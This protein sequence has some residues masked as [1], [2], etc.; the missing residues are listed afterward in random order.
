M[1]LERALHQIAEIHGHLA[2]SEVYRGYRSLPLALSG[3]IALAAAGL[4]ETVLVPE[5]DVAFV[6]YWVVIAAICGALSSSEVIYHYLFRDDAFRRRKTRRV[7]GQFL[8]SLIGGGALTVCLVKSGPS[9][10]SLIPGLWAILFGM[11]IFASRPYLPRAIG[12]VGLFYLIA[13]NLLL[14]LSGGGGLNPWGM[15][16]TFGTGQLLT[17]L[18]LYWN[19]ERREHA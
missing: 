18:V 16:V 7:T 17:A 5:T 2:R 12:W 15:G 1:E 19:I 8:P 4:Q 10:V 3:F 11:G 14:L 13:G 9:A 6:S